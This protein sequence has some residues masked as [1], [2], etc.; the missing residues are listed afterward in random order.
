MKGGE[1][2]P[3]P[4]ALNVLLGVVVFA[5]DVMEHRKQQSNIAG[6]D[7]EIYSYGT[8]EDEFEGKDAED[9]KI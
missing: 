4:R 6:D 7:C 9:G 1:A 8:G 3:A 5:P 2:E